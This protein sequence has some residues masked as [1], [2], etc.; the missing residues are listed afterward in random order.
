MT[1]LHWGAIQGSAGVEPTG[2]IRCWIGCLKGKIA[3]V[4]QQRSTDP[5]PVEALSQKP[6]V[7]PF[8]PLVELE[9]LLKVAGSVT[10]DANQAWADIWKEFK[11]FVTPGGAI[12]PEA[13]DGFVPACGWAEFLEKLWLLKHYLDSVQRICTKQH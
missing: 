13:K 3:V 11:P 2:P 6:N 5:Y 4:P 1:L 9:H 12:R 10:Q 7:L 8:T